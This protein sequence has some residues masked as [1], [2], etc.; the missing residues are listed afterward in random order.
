MI[1]S[2]NSE[3]SGQSAQQGQRCRKKSHMAL[4]QT[5]LVGGLLETNPRTGLDGI[6]K[7]KLRM[8][9]RPTL[10]SAAA[11]QL[12]M[13]EESTE[14]LKRF[15]GLSLQFAIAHRQ[16]PLMHPNTSNGVTAHQHGRLGAG[17]RKPFPIRRLTPVG[18]PWSCIAEQ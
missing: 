10:T 9:R 6:P 18:T 5:K 15:Q 17:T 3:T 2:A 13:R 12:R 7:Q 14:D 11:L 8:V 16:L 1:S 4:D